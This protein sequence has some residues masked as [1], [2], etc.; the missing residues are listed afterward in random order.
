MVVVSILKTNGRLGNPKTIASEQP[1]R[2]KLF[3]CAQCGQKQR[4]E[5]A[6]FGT[7]YICTKCG[8]ELSEEV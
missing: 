2:S 4:I 8:H 6:E 7:R 1:N 3:V 5:N